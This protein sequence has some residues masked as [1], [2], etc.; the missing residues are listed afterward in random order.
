[1]NFL[2]ADPSVF[3]RGVHGL[4]GHVGVVKVISA[5]GFLKLC[6]QNELISGIE[7]IGENLNKLT[8]VM[9]TPM[10]YTGFAVLTT[11]FNFAELIVDNCLVSELLL[12]LIT[13]T[14]RLLR[15][16]ISLR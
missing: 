5:P 2:V 6:S 15:F 9:P 4:L 16:N 10:T 7:L 8:L 11:I 1:M 3:E 12:D 14:L 13:V